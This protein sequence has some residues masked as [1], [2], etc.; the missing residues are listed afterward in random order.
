VTPTVDLAVGLAASANPSIVNSNLIYTITLTNAGPST[1]TGVLLTDLLPAGITNAVSSSTTQGS[2]TTNGA[3][4]L[5][6]NVGTLAKDATVTATLVI[7][8]TALGTITN[9]IIAVA[10]ETDANPLNN[11]ATTVTAVSQPTADLA[12]GLV[13][14]PDPIAVGAILTY[15]ITVT[16]LGPATAV[17]VIVTNT[18][19]AGVTIASVIPPGGSTNGSVITYGLGNIGSGGVGTFVIQVTPTVAGTITNTAVVNSDVQDPLKGNNRASVKTV[20]QGAQLSV[21]ASGGVLT[22]QWPVGGG[23][24]ALQSTPSLTPPVVWSLV[25]PTSQTVQNGQNVA[26]VNILPGTLFFRLVQT[27]P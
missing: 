17:N 3:G 9:T 2:W 18:L 14:A 15:T 20:V 22:F 27:G 21:S 11:T 25:T 26:T 23:T 16:N 4:Q 12:I 10:N 7:A 24:Y 13:D 1:A 19:P 5:V 8:P 6:C